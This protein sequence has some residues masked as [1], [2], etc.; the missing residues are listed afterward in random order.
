MPCRDATANAAGCIVIAKCADDPSVDDPPF[1][2][3]PRPGVQKYLDYL[4]GLGAI[5]A[6]AIYLEKVVGKEASIARP[7]RLPLVTAQI[8]DRS[9]CFLSGPAGGPGNP[10]SSIAGVCLTNCSADHKQ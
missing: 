8:A 10:A 4:P 7:P 5:R 2:W 1:A 3:L 9:R 6:I